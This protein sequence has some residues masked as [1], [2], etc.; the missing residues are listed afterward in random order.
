MNWPNGLIRQ[1]GRG[2]SVALTC[3]NVTDEIARTAVANIGSDNV[4]V[5]L[6]T[7]ELGVGAD[8]TVASRAPRPRCCPAT[9]SPAP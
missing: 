2:T 4:S 6:N 7:T 9:R 3:M 8:L 5:L 1:D